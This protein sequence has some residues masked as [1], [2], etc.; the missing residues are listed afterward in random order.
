MQDDGTGIY[1]SCFALG[2]DTRRALR[3]GVHTMSLLLCCLLALAIPANSLKCY[4]CVG[5]DNECSPTEETCPGQNAVCSTSALHIDSFPCKVRKVLKGCVNSTTTTNKISISPSQLVTFSLQQETCNSDL[6]NKKISDPDS[7]RNDLYCHSCISP[8]INCDS[9]KMNEMRCTGEQN[10]CVDMSVIGSFG[11]IADVSIKGCAHLPSYKENM[12]FSSQTSSVTIQGCH[13]NF[14]N[15]VI[16]YEQEDKTPNGIQCYSCNTLDGAGCS[17]G[18]LDK[19]QCYGALTSCLHIEGTVTKDGHQIP[20]MIKGCATPSMCDSSVLPLLQ[21]LE[22]ATV[23]CCNGSLC[24]NQS[25]DSSLQGSGYFPIGNASPGTGI[26][27]TSSSD[28]THGETFRRR[29][30]SGSPVKT[31]H[32]ANSKYGSGSSSTYHNDDGSS[33]FNGPIMCPGNSNTQGIKGGSWNSNSNTGY[34]NPSFNSESES[35]TVPNSK[36]YSLGESNFS[37]LSL[38]GSAVGEEGAPHTSNSSDS[39]VSSFTDEPTTFSDLNSYG[40][41]SIGTNSYYDNIVNDQD[42]NDFNNYESGSFTEIVYVAIDLN[43]GQPGSPTVA[44]GSMDSNSYDS[45]GNS[46]TVTSAYNPNIVLSANNNDSTQHL[47]PETVKPHNSGVKQPNS[48]HGS[49]IYNTGIANNN[50]SGNLS[51]SGNNSAGSGNNSS[52]GTTGSSSFGG[53]TNMP[54]GNTSS[55]PY[56]SSGNGTGMTSEWN[57]S[58]N[59]SNHNVVVPVGYVNIPGKNHSSPSHS[60]SDYGTGITNEWIYS[61]DSNHNMAAPVGYNNISA[62]NHSSTYYTGNGTGMT[63]EGSNS[64]SSNHSMSVP[65]GYA[66]VSGGNGS[67]TYYASYGN[68]T[69]MTHEGINSSSSNHS[70]SVPGGYANVSGGNGS[71]TSYA[72]YGNG[73]GMTHEGINSSSSNHSMSVPGGYAN[74]S[75]GN[76]SSTYYASY[77]NGTGMTHEGINSSSSNHSM[78]VPGGYANVSGGNGSSTSY[79][80]SGNGTGMTHEGINSS[81]SNHSMSVPGGYANVSG[82]NGSSTSYASYGNGT[83]MT[84]NGINS[85]SSNHSMSVPGGYANVSGGNGSSTS[86]ASYGNGTGMTHEG[87]NSSSSNHSMSVPGGYA[88]VSGGNGSSTYYASYGN[89]T[90]MTHEGI[91]SSSSNHSMSVPGGYANVSR[92]NGSSTS[93]ASYGNGTGMTHEGINSSSSNHS[94]SVPGGYANVSGGNGSST[95]YASYGN[96]TGMTHEGINSSSSNHSMSVP[97][98]YANVS[99]GNGSSTSYASSGNGTGMTHEGINSSSSNHSMSVPGGYANVSGGNGSSTSYASSGNGTGMTHEGINSSSSN[100]SMSVPGGYANVSG[101]NGSSTSYAGNGTVPGGSSYYNGTAWIYSSS[102]NPNMLPNS[103][104]SFSNYSGIQDFLSKLNGSSNESIRNNSYFLNHLPPGMNLNGSGPYN[105]NES[106]A[107]YFNSLGLVNNPNLTYVSGGNNGSL[108]HGDSFNNGI[109]TGHESVNSSSYNP[110]MMIPGVGSG[111]TDGNNM[112]HGLNGSMLGSG[113]NTNEL[114]PGRYTNDSTIGYAGNSTGN[115]TIYNGAS[116][117]W[118]KSGSFVIFS[119]IVL[120]VLS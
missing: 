89:G 48:G 56:T 40:G 55:T 66:N 74:V 73:T 84:H 49:N 86:Y 93:Y 15:S 99:G 67:S 88:N 102:F 39:D 111:V 69:G 43:N 85:S 105:I 45:V 13:G 78:S 9:D 110:N 35:H 72:S 11:D 95:Y 77:G 8:E 41:S 31:G 33:E 98:G 65:G 120:L 87:I 6:C 59:S 61:N 28:A 119:A 94:M 97:G 37:T 18:E 42:N 92:G 106:L 75:G 107:D 83:G 104:G 52:A 12:A 26:Q 20:T 14:C 19:A 108:N 71:S 27:N 112:G 36:N 101:G 51:S 54:G 16:E 22:A 64:S 46:G 10:L 24:N 23:K 118:A 1:T 76:G 115:G 38:G 80:S 47:A 117:P 82:G 62:N 116:S 96:G 114:V 25:S 17:P 79:A 57:N 32:H 7:N 2:Q 44:P 58:N 21:K 103:N 70:M 91:N 53:Y 4:K 81:S 109:N 63:Y 60:S 50:G 100:H 29:K 68:G 5:N 113:S 30:R 90:G 3:M 34:S